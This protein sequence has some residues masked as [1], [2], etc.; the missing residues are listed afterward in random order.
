MREAFVFAKPRGFRPYAAKIL[1][2]QVAPHGRNHCVINLAFEWMLLDIKYSPLEPIGS[3]LHDKERVSQR[4]S[5]PPPS[6]IPLATFTVASCFQLDDVVEAMA[7]DSVYF[8]VRI[9]EA[10]VPANV[11]QDL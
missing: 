9:L 1:H 2:V 11:N 3:S 5:S 6:P 10:A 8:R 4:F 7:A